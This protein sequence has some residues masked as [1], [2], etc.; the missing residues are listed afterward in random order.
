[1]LGHMRLVLRMLEEPRT[2]TVRIRDGLL[3]GERLAGD[4]EEGRLRVAK[5]ESLREMCTVDVGHEMRGEIAFGIGLESLCHHDGPKIGAADADVH[6][7]VDRLPSVALPRAV[8][9]GI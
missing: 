8:A 1:M 5:A 6:D 9:H 3:C 4:N 2:C 7:R